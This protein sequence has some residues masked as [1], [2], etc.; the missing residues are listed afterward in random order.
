MKQYPLYKH[1]AVISI[2]NVVLLAKNKMAIWH[3][4]WKRANPAAFFLRMQTAQLLDMIEKGL[5][6]AYRPKVYAFHESL[7]YE[8]Q[9]PDECRECFCHKKELNGQIITCFKKYHCDTW[10]KYVKD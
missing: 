9:V 7:P 8:N 4:G 2:D 3:N 5:L 10:T 6:Y 1:D